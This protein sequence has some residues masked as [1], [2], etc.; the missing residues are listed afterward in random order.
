MLFVIYLFGQL[1]FEPASAALGT[2]PIS[3]I[4]NPPVI[5]APNIAKFFLLFILLL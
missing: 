5:K 3:P 2:K 1:I 4:P